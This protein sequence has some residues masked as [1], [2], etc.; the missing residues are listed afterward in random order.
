M[1]NLKDKL[2]ADF[3]AR[4]EEQL[5]QGFQEF[6]D[7]YEKPAHRGISINYRKI[8]PE[9]FE[10]IAPF[11]IEKIPWAKGAYYVLEDFDLARH[12]LYHAGIYYIQEPSAM[13]PAGI[14]ISQ[15]FK[16]KSSEE[17]AHSAHSEH[18][19]FGAVLLDACSAPGGKAMQLSQVLEGRGLI[20]ANDNS[21]IRIKA[22]IRHAERYGLRDIIITR[23]DAQNLGFLSE[24]CSH[25]LVD[26]PCSGE[27]M[28]RKDERAVKAYNNFGPEFY[29]KIQTEILSGLTKDFKGEMV[30][31]TCT[32]SPLENQ[33]SLDAAVGMQLLYERTIYPHIEKGEGHFVAALAPWEPEPS[34]QQQ[35][36]CQKNTEMPKNLQRPTAKEFEVIQA[37][38]E[39]HISER[40]LQAF[41]RP[42]P[43]IREN[44]EKHGTQVYLVPQIHVDLPDD[45]VARKGLLIASIAGRSGLQPEQ[46]LAHFVDPAEYKFKIEL[47]LDGAIKY[48]KGETLP[49]D[50][51]LPPAFYLMTYKSFG[52]GFAG[53]KNG[54][55]KNRYAKN[56]RIRK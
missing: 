56:W 49:V 40:G 53:V 11:K 10:E 9:K 20:I 3:L 44:L 23:S 33:R 25:M 39:K 48:L 55:F 24:Q 7:E 45:I 32:F 16:D 43:K 36:E 18:S 51:Q 17:S 26:A 2:P 42:N 13:A 50:T 21:D 54:V 47:D 30:Y 29:H 19:A 27:G 14:L 12:P 38:L 22:V 34:E 8:S 46:G 4:M 31:S 15:S 37:F 6:L 1:S 35:A 5:G 28:F 41:K 52:L